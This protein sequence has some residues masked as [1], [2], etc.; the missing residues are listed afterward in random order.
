MSENTFHLN[1]IKR[2]TYFV[3]LNKRSQYLA[4]FFSGVSKKLLG[5]VKTFGKI[6]PVDK[7]HQHKLYSNPDKTVGE[8]HET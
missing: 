6:C 1:A 4:Q 3:L 2:D 7:V 8:Y 5:E